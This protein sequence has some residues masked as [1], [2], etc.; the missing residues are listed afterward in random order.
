MELHLKIIGII[1]ILLAMVHF[2]FPKIFNW[3]TELSQ[4][5][6]INKQLMH[7]HTFF[8]ALTVFLTGLLCL[9]CS[10]DLIETRLGKLVILGLLIFWGFR[11]LFQFFVYSPE[12]WR[13]KKTETTVHIIFSI[14]WIY[15]NSVFLII[16]LS[17]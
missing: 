14:I 13:G 16:E 10:E 1:S 2:I 17:I 5:S 15:F 6:L 3:E 8:I 7:V 9:F 12:L 4:L 11:L